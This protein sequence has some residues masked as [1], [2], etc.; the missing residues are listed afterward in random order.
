MAGDKVQLTFFEQLDLGQGAEA[1][2]SADIR[3]FYQRLDLTGEH[4]VGADGSINI[5]LLGR[6]DIG[7]MTADEARIKV[8]EAY[9][10]TM[11]KSGEVNIKVV[12]RKPVFVTGIVKSPGSFRYEPGMI[13]AQAIALAGGYDRPAEAAARIF[14]AQREREKRAQAVNRLE[15]LVARRSRLV[16]QRALMES[17][18][19]GQGVERQKTA[20][21]EIG[22]LM[23]AELRLLD[24]EMSARSAELSLNSAKLSSAKEQL[25]ALKK[26]SDIV[27]QQIGA[28]AERM[29]VLQK[30]QGSGNSTLE[31]LWN[32]QKE[33]AD[34]QMQEGRLAAEIGSAESDIV[35]AEAEAEKIKSSRNV[36]IERELTSVEEEIDQLR[37]AIDATE[38]TILDL[39]TSTS[40]ARIGEQLYLKILRRTPAGTSV[41]NADES[42]DLRPGDVV[43]VGVNSETGNALA[44]AA[45]SSL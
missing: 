41:L 35:Q 5:A 27:A 8:M 34:L 22:E 31:A 25:N 40:G 9:R 29:R 14:D 37:T 43:K 28:R 44:A 19:A 1:G 38:A 24:A 10:T 6:F 45:P 20:G 39:E 13:T 33:V 7:G 12:E 30:M 21:D 17:S 18:G 2:M 15:R 36:E 26:I 42:A 16:S 11:G 32:A 3:T 4:V 23:E